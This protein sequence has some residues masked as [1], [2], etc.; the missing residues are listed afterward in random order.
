MKLEFSDRF[1]KNIQNMKFHENPSSGGQVVTFRQ[2]DRHDE[3]TICLSQF[4]E[5]V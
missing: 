5:C 2:M 3:F 4:Y 1:T